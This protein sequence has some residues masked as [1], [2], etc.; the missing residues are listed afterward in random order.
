LVKHCS[1]LINFGRN[2]P[3]KML[4][5]EIILFLTSPNWCFC[6]SWGNNL[7]QKGQILSI[8]LSL[9]CLIWSIKRQVTKSA[10]LVHR[11]YGASSDGAQSKINFKLSPLCANTSSQI[12][13]PL[14][15]TDTIS[16]LLKVEWVHSRWFGE[17]F[18][19]LVLD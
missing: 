9:Y 18:L 5:D 15:A 19:C 16:D 1:I 13:S 10:H 3:E 6:T 4:L 2:I 7:K 17:M 14:M 12:F 11:K 8:F